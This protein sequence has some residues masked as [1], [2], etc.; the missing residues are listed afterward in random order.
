MANILGLALKISAD[1]TGVQ[2]KLTPVERALNQLDEQANKSAQVFQEFAKTTVAAVEAQAQVGTDIAAITEQLRTGQITAQEFAKAFATVEANAAAL[3]RTF[4]EGARLTESLRTAEE[5]RAIELER[6][7]ALLRAGAITEDIAARA[8]LEASGANAASAKAEG[9]RAAAVADASRIIRANL[10]P[11][12]KYDLTVRE[13]STHL[14]EGRLTQEQFN[15]AVANARDGLNTTAKA[16][17]DTDRNIDK[18]NQNLKFL[19]NLQLG[20]AI[21]DGLQ[22]LGSTFTSVTN[23]LASVVSSVNTSLDTL[24]DF[25]ARTGI[26]VEALQGY[27]LAA[28]LAGVDTEQFGVAVQKLAV[29]IGKATPGDQLDRSLANINLSVRELRALSPESQFQAIGNAISALPT[30]AERAAAAVEIFGRQGAALAPLF[31]EGAAGIE[32]LKSRAER[33]GIIV[34]ETQINN[35]A[36]MNDA[37]D[38]VS[39]TINGIIGQVIGNLAPAVTS[40]TDELLKFVETF[41]GA[42]GTGGTGIAN[43]I[44]ETLFNGGE[45]LA[46]VFDEF[47]KN[48]DGFAIGLAS[49]ADVFNAVANTFT[50]VT[51]SIRA[52]F[53]FFEVSGNLLLVGLGKFLEGLGSYVSSDLQK[54]GQQVQVQANDA[55]QRNAREAE[56]AAAN[57]SA[58]FGRVFN[59]ESA[60]AA[61]DGAASRAIRAARERFA[62]E[63]APEFKVN[64]NLDKASASLEN[65]LK[66]A[67]DG[68]DEFLKK[69]QQTLEVFKAQAAEGKLL[70]EQIQIMNGFVDQLNQKL[71]YE[72]ELRQQAREETTKQAEDDRK[73]IDELLKKSDAVNQLQLDADAIARESARV[74]EQL[75][76]AREQGLA[77][78]ANAAAARLAQLDQIGAKVEEQLQA[79]AQGFSDG[80][81]KAFEAT[82]K[83]IDSLIVKAERFGNVG[84][85]AAQALEQ[86][87]QRAQDQAKDGILNR[88]AYDRE[89]ARQQQL[90]N[91]RLAAA[92]RVEDFLMSR[93]DDRQRAE[94]DAT[95][96]LE[97]R[98]KQ[99]ATNVQAIEAKLLDQQ[100]ALEEARSSGRLKDAKA[101]QARISDL[102]AVQRSEQAIADGRTQADRLQTQQLTA[103]AQRQQQFQSLIGQQNQN[104]LN[105]FANTYTGANNALAQANAV[106]EQQAAKLQ[107]ILTPGPRTV[108]GADVRTAAGAALVI[109]L[110]AT[111][112][113]PALIEARLQN[114]AL[115]AIRTAIVNATTN[116]L[117][118]PVAIL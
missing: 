91:E 9:V 51:E 31:R 101:T 54:I 112:Q 44:T 13:L 99:A 60:A 47:V 116:Y 97:E 42:Q 102:K 43:A 46:S 110:V 92:Q 1:A 45:Y 115:N 25:S 107:Q 89:I 74:L 57:A 3:G 58:A 77:D 86:G 37:F 41:A 118:T 104:F 36:S 73:R 95:K 56:A 70:P 6:I 113:D 109:G 55:A 72:L 8:K 24:N 87:I 29:N 103:T 53:N 22:L 12:E 15:R 21:V 79:E 81:G 78:E 80:F 93:L 67:G 26:G 50:V 59:G 88:E 76:A 5:K 94:L 23:Q 68:A 62:R 48:F 40:V 28:K 38:L 7:D 52:V 83:G 63:Q 100:K 27:S 66:Q 34:S 19:K 39:A 65:Y 106:A 84:A 61:G 117:D 33:L 75:A 114:K 85:F 2:Q 17:S 30:A 108:Q 90:F 35:V 96:Q 18:L 69:S 4:A 105:A 49:S 20:R 82:R 111:E 16:A 10:T 11:Q 98:K 32:E 64:A 14:R 71:A